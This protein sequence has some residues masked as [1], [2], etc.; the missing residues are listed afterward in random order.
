MSDAY[1]KNKQEGRRRINYVFKLIKKPIFSLLI[2]GII[3]LT[4]RLYYF[5]FGIPIIFDGVDYFSYAV[6]INQQGHLPVNWNLS[7]NGWP[8]FLSAFFSIFDSQKFLELTYLQ[9]FLSITISVLTIIPVYLLCSRFVKKQ[10]AVIGAALFILEPRIIIN[11]LL[12]IPEP[13]FILLSTISLFL[14]LS[15]RHTV[16]LISFFTLALCSTIRYEGFLLL[17]P[18]LIIFFVRFRKDKKIIKKILLCI[19]I[20]FITISPVAYI[21]YEATGNDGIIYPILGGSINYISTHIINGIPDIDDPIYGE[22]IKEDRLT[23]FFSLGIINTIKFLGWISVPTFLIFV[24][25]GIILLFQ[26]RDY[27]T[28]TIILCITTMLIPAF[29]AYGRGIEE[30]RYLYVIFPILCIISSLS[31]EKI[32]QKIKKEKIII[33]III[34]GIL[35]SSLIFLDY[36][37]IDYQYE[38]ESYLIANHIEKNVGGINH[39]SQWKYIPV[40][41]IKNNWPVIPIPK[42]NNYDQPVKVKRSDPNGYTTLIDY[43]EDNNSKGLT[44]LVVDG[45]QYPEFLN[46]IFHNEDIP[47]LIKK[48]DSRNDGYN[49]HV[50]VFEIDYEL[51]PKK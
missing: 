23:K 15:K 43:I 39:W 1:S 50:K 16:I 47:Y 13:G 14:L 34:F 42:E 3:G 28:F 36:K 45:N 51:L 33:I 8:I 10:F 18:F 21:M 48:Y 46:T 4:I 20:F 30:T 17:F 40:S 5:P 25:I 9:R 49:Y 37:K 24:P 38:K 22:D 41:E 44:H 29:Y 6:V 27:K 2:I 35:I 11:S 7:N 19:S 12:G 32:S 31:I 26:N